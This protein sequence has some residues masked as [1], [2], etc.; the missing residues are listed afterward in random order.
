[1]VPG[2]SPGRD[3]IPTT[4][5]FKKNE[6]TSSTTQLCLCDFVSTMRFTQVWS[7]AQVVPILFQAALG[8]LS[9]FLATI[10]RVHL[11]V[12]ANGGGGHL[13]RHLSGG[14][15]AK[16]INK[17]AKR[18]KAITSGAWAT[19]LALNGTRDRVWHS[20]LANPP[21]FCGTTVETVLF[22][23]FCQSLCYSSDLFER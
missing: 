17:N 7:E 5:A 12:G 13:C 23:F 8:H 16:R 22:A 18:N 10:Q 9:G 19:R 3:L 21:V 4:R 11:L 15:S 2:T 1:M 14:E 6:V 20:F